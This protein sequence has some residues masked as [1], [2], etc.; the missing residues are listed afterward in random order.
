L[1]G[2]IAQ[3]PKFTRF[4]DALNGLGSLRATRRRVESAAE[5]F[6]E[7]IFPRKIRA[8]PAESS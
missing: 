3:L 8:P 1:F 4:S 5:H 2:A 7:R 6:D